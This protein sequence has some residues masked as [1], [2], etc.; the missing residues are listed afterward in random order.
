MSTLRVFISSTMRDLDTERRLLR[1]RIAELN[2]QPVNA[3]DIAPT[4]QRSWERIEQELESCNVMVL[5]QGSSYGWVPTSGPSAG[6]GKSIT[7]LEYLKA[8]ELDLPILPFQKVLDYDIDGKTPDAAQ[9]DA[10][11]KEVGDWA[12]GK[13][14]AK[15]EHG[16]ELP[17]LVVKGLVTMLGDEFQKQRINARASKAAEQ[18]KAVGNGEPAA[19][20]LYKPVI[21]NTLVDAIAGNRAILFAGAGISLAAGLPSHSLFAARANELIAQRDPMHAGDGVPF[22]RLADQL[23]A[24]G[25]RAELLQLVQTLIQPPVEPRPTRAHVIAT[26]LFRRIVTSN[27]DELFEYAIFSERPQR[28]RIATELNGDSLPG[29]VLVKLHG[30]ISEPETLLL[31]E[32]ETALLDLRRPR[33]WRA[34]VDELGRNTCV[35]IGSSL[36]DVS[37]VRL[38][39]EVGR[40]L[41]GYFIAPRVSEAEG[42]VLAQIGLDVIRSAADEFFATVES[43]VAERRKQ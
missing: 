9:R 20:G 30:T 6:K 22:A 16:D 34:L 17:E 10:F 31:S 4:G 19:T 14:F 18:A 42:A 24:L 15:W 8:R 35:V 28:Q 11:R 41:S 12:D 21:P 1:K 37:I 43:K 7:H 39:A 2:F 5:L 3:E 26:R 29:S 40:Q 27:Y 13:F 33:M 36:R 32:R 23:E 38:F 25:G